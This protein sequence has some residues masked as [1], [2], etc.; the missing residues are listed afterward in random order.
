MLEDFRLKVFEAVAKSGSFTAA[1][2]QLGVS[3]PAVSQNIAETE[4]TVGVKL[5]DRGA[6]RCTLTPEG[7]AFLGYARE[8]NEAYGRMNAVFSRPESTLLKS[9]VLDGK[10][11]NILIE[12]GYFSSIGVPDDTPAERVVDDRDS[13]RRPHSGPVHHRHRLFYIKIHIREEGGAG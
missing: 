1:A 5:F 8:V 7:K 2:R 4:K 12:K 13:N 10:P 11:C 9:V 3:Q 6:G